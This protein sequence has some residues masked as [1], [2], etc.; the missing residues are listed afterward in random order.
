MWSGLG[1]EITRDGQRCF[2]CDVASDV[3]PAVMAW[4]DLVDWQVREAGD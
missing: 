1:G 3:T 4:A 2:E